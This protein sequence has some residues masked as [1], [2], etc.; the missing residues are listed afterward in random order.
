MAVN[1]FSQTAAPARFSPLSFQEQAVAPLMLRAREDEMNNATDTIFNNLN[2]IETVDKYQGAVDT[3]REAMRNELSTLAEKI[4]KEGAGNLNYL[5]EFRNL[6][7]KYN[8]SV[9]KTG[10]LGRA[11]GVKADLDTMKDAWYADAYKKGQPA[12]QI[13]R[14]WVIQKD[15]YLNGLPSDLTKV[16]GSLPQFTPEFAPDSVS[17]SDSVKEL[18]QFATGAQEAIQGGFSWSQAP[19]GSLIAISNTDGTEVTNIPQIDALKKQLQSTLLNPDSPLNRNLKWRNIDPNSLINDIDNY[20]VMM[21]KTSTKDVTDFKQVSGGGGS[22]STSNP[23]GSGKTG[24]ESLQRY[25]TGLPKVI[26]SKTTVDLKNEIEK[27]KTDET[28]TQQEK[29]RKL[30]EYNHYLLEKKKLENSS[31]FK[32]RADVAVK[33]NNTFKWRGI[34]N[35]EDY[36]KWIEDPNNELLFNIKK[37]L[38][39]YKKQKEISPMRG[40]GKIDPVYEKLSLLSGTKLKEALSGD[41]GNADIEELLARKQSFSDDNVFSTNREKFTKAPALKLAEEGL[42]KTY[43]EI[44]KDLLKPVSFYHYGIETDGGKLQKALDDGFN[45][46]PIT[47]MANEGLIRIADEDGTFPDNLEGNPNATSTK[48]GEPYKELNNMLSTSSETHFN[49]VGLT[50]GGINSNAKLQ[51]NVVTKN[52]KDYNTKKIEIELDPTKLDTLTNQFLNPGGTYYS[53]L[54]AAGQAVMDGIRDKNEYGSVPTDISSINDP[55]KIYNSTDTKNIINHA[56]KARIKDSNLRI[57]SKDDYA[58][59]YFFINK[60]D[61][62]D[63]SVDINEDNSYT[64]YKKD[65]DGNIIPFTFKD[66][67]KQGFF[68]EAY[69]TG[70]IEDLKG[71]EDFALQQARAW[72]MLNI[73]EITPNVDELDNTAIIYNTDPIFLETLKEAHLKYGDYGKEQLKNLSESEVIEIASYF[74][75]IENLPVRSKRIKEVL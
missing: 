73:M 47:A 48:G 18:A 66:H 17:L 6:R 57:K 23:R 31:D 28:L 32:E 69:K 72:D 70:Q 43:E 26:N 37:E 63:Y 22:G 4:Q 19:D 2:Q 56:D 8:S 71:K 15:R 29:D 3:E 60:E 9:G 34:N 65:S 58:N 41:W 62:Y 51:F 36:T 67:A 59:K 40:G 12:E 14:N 7:N 16:K 49:F 33:D 74:K 5:N 54:D 68:K 21:T 35:Y 46:Q 13:D 75:K 1:R 27:I 11:A 53:A 52:D 55:N 42:S 30:T 25:A 39:L 10:I 45:R 38:A 24:T 20:G 64:T 50:D 61:N 44:N